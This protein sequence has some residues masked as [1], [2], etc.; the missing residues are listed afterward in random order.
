MKHK[1]GDKITYD[2]PLCGG[3]KYE[4]K[5][6]ELEMENVYKV[7]ILKIICPSRSPIAP[8]KVGDIDHVILK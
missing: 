1:V 3:G 8:Q 6:L 5:I 4:A 2:L 7:K